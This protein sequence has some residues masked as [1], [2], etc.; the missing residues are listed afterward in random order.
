MFGIAERGSERQFMQGKLP[1]LGR[2]GKLTVLKKIKT[3]VL[4]KKIVVCALI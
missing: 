2:L 3:V 4:R 1:G